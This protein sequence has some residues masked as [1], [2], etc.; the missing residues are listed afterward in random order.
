MNRE[1]FELHD[2]DYD[3]WSDQLSYQAQLEQEEEENEQE[4]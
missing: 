3:E 1:Y 4:D 2:P